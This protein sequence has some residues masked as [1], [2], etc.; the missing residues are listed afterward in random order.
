MKPNLY[1]FV[2]PSGVVINKTYAFSLQMACGVFKLVHTKLT[3]KQIE[4]F[5][6][7]HDEA[8]EFY[9]WKTQLALALSQKEPA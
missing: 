1:F 7:S 6:I 9:N 2:S 3:L 5:T 8:L 4:E